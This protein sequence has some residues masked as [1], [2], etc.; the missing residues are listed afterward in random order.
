MRGEALIQAEVVG[1]ERELDAL[2]RRLDAA[3]GGQGSVLVLAGEPGIG[4]THLARTLAEA[5]DELGFSVLWGSCYEGD[6]APPLGPWIDA[7]HNRVRKGDGERLGSDYVV[8][9][10]LLPELGVGAANAP[11][12]PPLEPIEERYRLYDAVARILVDSGE[13]ILVVLDDLQWADTASLELLDYAARAVAHARLVV[14]A[15]YRDDLPLEH[16]LTRLVAELARRGVGERLALANL[17][18]GETA[19]LVEQLHRRPVSPA[20]ASAIYE[21][22]KGNPFFVEE[23]VRHLEDEGVDLASPDIELGEA[24]VPRGVR[25]ALA[26]RLAR[27]SPATVRMLELA[28]AFTGGFD[29]RILEALLDEQE[30]TILD[31]LDEA[32]RARFIRPLEGGSESYDFR[33]AIVRHA[34]FDEVAPSR[35]ARVHRKIATALQRALADRTDDYAGQLAEHYWRSGSL[36]GAAN[37]LP[38]ALAAAARA[39]ARYAHAD[40]AKF[41]RIARDL[42]SD[43]EPGVQ[44]DV[45]RR[46]ALA[47]A[48]AL[49]LDDSARTVDDA[50]DAT[51]RAG[52]PHSDT[53]Q[54]L[55]NVAWALKDAGAKRETLAA[56]VRRG[57]VVNGDDRGLTW[58]KLKLVLDPVEPRARG[59]LRFQHWIGFDKEAVAIARASGDEDAY[60]RTLD[61]ADRRS[62]EETQALLELVRG[63]THAPAKVRALSVV[64]RSFIYWSGALRDAASVCRELLAVSERFGSLAGQ[65]Y[66]LAM[67]AELEMAL[68][69][70]SD[71]A[72]A[73]ARARDLV[74]RLGSHHRL[75]NIVENASELYVTYVGGDVLPF[76]K[77]YTRLAK[78]GS[79]TAQ[80]QLAAAA[81][82]VRAWGQLGERGEAQA[83][84]ADLTPALLARSPDD[85]AQSGNV[86]NVADAAWELGLV[87]WAETYRTLA[88]DLIEAGIGDNSG[89]SHELVVARMAALLGQLDEAHEYFERARRVL[90]AS[91]QRPLRAIVDFDEAV[92]AARGRRPEAADLVAAARRQFEAIGMALWLDRAD[93][94][95]RSL[96]ERASARPDGLTRR[97]VEVL[98]LLAEGRMNK[99]IAK[100]LSLSVRT[101]ERHVLNIYAKIGARR[102]ADAATYATRVGI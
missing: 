77:S 62:R 40:A 47:E 31:C 2:E 67:L 101:V 22:T 100:E 83:L 88:L 23:L 21:Q 82:A 90:E 81:V 15:T 35:R 61:P 38:Y 32:L 42:A 3:R 80:G 69:N 78:D 10:R 53:A 18:G 25:D 16:P 39:K 96:E 87:E 41:L 89:H 24:G 43:A 102:R 34:L 45:L 68:G 86:S 51:A 97:E 33:H 49:L 46:L 85:I 79:Y 63:W 26:A 91:G 84:I 73:H 50:L 74:G 60:A 93:E 19:D 56:I 72:D 7:V 59:E 48:E 66:A 4:K 8:L 17:T 52:A 27:L 6:W 58:A 57:L 70:F 12:V 65:A 55:V 64:A 54:F 20:V 30:Q 9:A 92:V 94:L 36:P 98:R 99:E 1:R 44:A 28:S 5:A 76:A 29:V 95:V 75:H 37:G 14:V 11:T 71:A 13:P